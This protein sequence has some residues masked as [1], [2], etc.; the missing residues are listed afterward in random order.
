M[1]DLLLLKEKE[2]KQLKEINSGYPFELKKGEKLMS[3]IFN[4]M[5]QAICR[6]LICKNTD[7]FCK[8]LNLFYEKYPEYRK[9]E[10]SF[11]YNGKKINQNLTLEENGIEDGGKIIILYKEE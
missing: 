6:S 1:I 2:I 10:N 4:S 7:T 9:R 3:I 5:N 8:V 11:V